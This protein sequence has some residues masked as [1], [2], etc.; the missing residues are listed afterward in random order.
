[1]EHKDKD[2][3]VPPFL[4]LLDE[5][6]EAMKLGKSLTP[7]I[8]DGYKNQQVVDAVKESHKLNTRITILD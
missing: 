5:Y 2:H 6:A 3:R 1:M 8:F 7:S 4:K